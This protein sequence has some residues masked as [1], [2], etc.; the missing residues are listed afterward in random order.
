MEFKTVSYSATINLGNYSN[1]KIG[2]TVQPGEDETPEQV[3]EALRQKVK[4]IGGLNAETLYND[5]HFNRRKLEDLNRK[6]QKAT[7]QWNSTAEFLRAQGIKPDSPDMP[8]FMN[9]LPEVKE[10]LLAVVEGEIEEGG[11]F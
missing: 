3:V 8:Q 1:E 2:F 6:I 7:E 4:E 11:E 9:L 10:E 5:L